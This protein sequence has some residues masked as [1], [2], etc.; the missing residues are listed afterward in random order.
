MT[1]QLAAVVAEASLL[2]ATEQDALAA[3]LREELDSE[4]RWEESFA[5][6]ESQTM[7]ERLAEEAL[8]DQIAGRTRPLDLENL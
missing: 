6:P 3:I 5:R 2:P 4:R 7:L 8:A 1:S